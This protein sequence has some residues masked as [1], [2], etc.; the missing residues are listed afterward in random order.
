MGRNAVDAIGDAEQFHLIDEDFDQFPRHR[1]RARAFAELR[2]AASARGEDEMAKRLDWEVQLFS[3]AQPVRNLHEAT[4][5]PAFRPLFGFTDGSEWPDIP[6]LMANDQALEYFKQRAAKTTNADMRLRYADFL[7]EALRARK[8]REA[9]KYGELA[10]SA[11]VESSALYITRDSF[12]E[13]CEAIVRAGDIALTLNSP[14]SARKVGINAMQ[15]LETMPPD[16]RYRWALDLGWMLLRLHRSKLSDVVKAE[17]LLSMLKTCETGA[18]YFVEEGNY[19]L[20]RDC[21]E[22]AAYLGAATNGPGVAVPWRLRIVDSYERE[23]DEKSKL[24]GPAGGHLVA[25]HFYHDGLQECMN[26]KSVVED[27]EVRQK[28]EARMHV[29]QAKLS[30]SLD[31]APSEMGRIPI[32]IELPIDQLAP[33]VEH[34]LGLTPGEALR[35]LSSWDGILPDPMIVRKEAE[36]LASEKTLL[37]WLPFEVL[38]KGRKIGV[39]TDESK[40][41][42]H[43]ARVMDLMMVQHLGMLDFL[44][45]RLTAE[46]LL[47]KDAIMDHLSRWNLMDE[48]ALPLVDQAL[49]RYSVGD[50]TSAIY[51]LAPMVERVLKSMFKQ[52]GLPPLSI[53]SRNRIKEQTLGSFLDRPEVRETLGERVWRYAHYTLV[54]PLGLHLRTSVAHGWLD[55][56]QCNRQL[57][58][59]LIYI[60]I[61]LTRFALGSAPAEPGESPAAG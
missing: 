29:L 22:L 9:G 52:A 56:N 58:Q 32:E 60:L 39:F 30:A 4:P 59:V 45:A 5:S 31:S 34:L 47:N 16:E 57:A 11:Y 6:G 12:L 28:L 55:F 8:S 50:H 43:S 21:Y 20:E 10:I 26:L 24:P 49:E 33:L 19:F 41:R 23:G 46:G 48:G 37:N 13:A 38:S 35:A 40:V 54:D 51:I 27:D 3:L 7:W 36:K 53:P 17:Q 14:D 25:Y 44:F 15:T 1:D 18:D 61:V 2:N 42:L